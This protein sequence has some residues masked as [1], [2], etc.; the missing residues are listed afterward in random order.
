M[1]QRCT[2]CNLA[3]VTVQVF[4]DSDDVV[5]RF[6]GLFGVKQ[7]EDKS[8]DKTELKSTAPPNGKKP[9]RGASGAKQSKGSPSP[10]KVSGD[11]SEG[12]N[13]FARLFKK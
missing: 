7:K 2:L 8:A 13:P 9:I 6:L 5:G 10:D 3:F 4:Q 11:D 12:F 1:L